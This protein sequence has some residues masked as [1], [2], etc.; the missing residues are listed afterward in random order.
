[1]AIQPKTVNTPHPSGETD[2]HV[3]LPEHI[4]LYLAVDFQLDITMYILRLLKRLIATDDLL[5]HYQ[6]LSIKSRVN[7]KRFHRFLVAARLNVKWTFS[8]YLDD[9]QLIYVFILYNDKSWFD[10]ADHGNYQSDFKKY[11]C[12]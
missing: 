7:I 11:F 10:R 2:Y 5:N 4:Y 3:Q 9:R 8:T 12:I 1:M 6:S